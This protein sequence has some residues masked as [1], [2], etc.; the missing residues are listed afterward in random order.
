MSVSGWGLCADRCD[1]SEA[2]K[3][4]RFGG[5]KIGSKL[6]CEPLAGTALWNE[7]FVWRIYLSSP[8]V[9]IGHSMTRLSMYPVR[10]LMMSL[11]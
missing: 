8:W 5:S 11:A 9:F 10:I 7:G 6:V 1:V 2:N 3:P 4:P